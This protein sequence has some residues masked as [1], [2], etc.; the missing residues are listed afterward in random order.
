M[1]HEE[2]QACLDAEV[3][4]NYVDI[5]LTAQFEK[6]DIYAPGARP[7][8]YFAAYVLTLLFFTYAINQLDKFSL[9]IVAKPVAQ[10]LHY[11]NQECMVNNDVLGRFTASY[12]L[13]QAQLSRWSNLCSKRS[14]YLLMVHI[15]LLSKYAQHYVAVHI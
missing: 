14:E 3:N 2:R 12:N 6:E 8:R 13:S 11:G 1:S 9:S 10:E 5:A 4:G 15:L 7:N